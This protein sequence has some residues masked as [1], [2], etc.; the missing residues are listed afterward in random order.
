MK[1]SQE[2]SSFAGPSG[3]LR[4]WIPSLSQ[5][6]QQYGAPVASGLYTP[7]SY[8][9]QNVVTVQPTAEVFTPLANPLPEYMGYSI[10]TMLCCCM[11]LGSAALVYSLTT[12]DANMFGHQQ[13]ASR[14][15]R[16]A[17]IINHII[18]AVGLI[19]CLIYI[20]CIILPVVT[21]TRHS[22]L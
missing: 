2:G 22:Q 1:L 20:V 11:P 21:V 10:F 14:N 16:M 17:C 18:V 19:F 8:L 3:V 12:G 13:I 6:S 4:C 15:S 7:G 5:Q 9:V